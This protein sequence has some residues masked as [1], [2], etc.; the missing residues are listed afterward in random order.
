MKRKKQ[1]NIYKRS[2]TFARLRLLGNLEIDLQVELSNSEV[3]A[4]RT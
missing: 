3:A 2:M 1:A 4:Q